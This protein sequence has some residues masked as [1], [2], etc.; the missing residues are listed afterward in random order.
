MLPPVVRT[1]IP[2]SSPLLVDPLIFVHCLRLFLFV[3][4]CTSVSSSVCMPVLLISLFFTFF[5]MH[6][7]KEFIIIFPFLLFIRA[8]LSSGLS[9]G[10]FVAVRCWMYTVLYLLCTLSFSCILKSNPMQRMQ[11][12]DAALHAD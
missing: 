7:V 12:A 10:C 4:L 3:R 8:A 1:D 9:F 6:S 11:G 2:G 5:R